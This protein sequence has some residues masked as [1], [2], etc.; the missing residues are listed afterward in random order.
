MAFLYVDQPVNVGR[1]VVFKRFLRIF[2][3]KEN[4]RKRSVFDGKLL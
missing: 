4:G 3:S 2:L 1:H